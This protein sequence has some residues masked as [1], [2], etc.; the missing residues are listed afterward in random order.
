[1][2]RSCLLVCFVLAWSALA[3]PSFAASPVWKVSKGDKHL[4]LGGTFHLLAPSDHPLPSSFDK[5]FAEAAVVVFETS[6]DELAT[7]EFQQ[8]MLTAFTQK[9]GQ[10]LAQILSPS[11]HRRLTTYLAER[12]LSISVFSAFTPTGIALTITVMEYAN[13]G[14]T[15]EAGV[16]KHYWTQAKKAGKKTDQFESAD[17]QLSFLESLGKGKEDAL[18]S[19]TL[20]DISELPTTTEKFKRAWRSGDNDALEKIAI[21][22]MLKEFPEIYHTLLTKRNNAWFPKIEQMLTTPE[23]ELILVGA[24]HLAGNDGLLKMLTDQGYTIE[25]L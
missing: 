18:I 21:E 6:A 24:L 7:A 8:K 11:T 10:S 5:A 1:M 22:P 13:M 14:M 12:G 16:D 4:F 20:K 25:N 2:I 15:Q 9:S 3:S 17:Q 23:V 19:K